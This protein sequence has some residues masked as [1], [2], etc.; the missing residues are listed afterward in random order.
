MKGVSIY[1]SFYRTFDFYNDCIT[2]SLELNLNSPFQGSHGTT[3]NGGARHVRGGRRRRDPGGHHGAQEAL[4]VL[5]VSEPEGVPQQ[6]HEPF[7]QFHQ[8]RQRVRLIG[9][10]RM[11]EVAAG[12]HE[13]GGQECFRYLGVRSCPFQILI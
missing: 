11:E 6:R 1:F 3:R 9:R 8:P 13:D 2:V 5:P 7:R 4:H 12:S 10:L